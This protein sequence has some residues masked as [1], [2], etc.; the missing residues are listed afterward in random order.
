MFQDFFQLNPFVL[1]HSEA[2]GD[3]ILKVVGEFVEVGMDQGC[4][5]DLSIVL[6]RDVT[7]GHVVEEDTQGPHR[8]A[9]GV[10]SSVLYPLRRSVHVGT[11]KG[12]VDIVLENSSRPEIYQSNV[13]CFFIYDDV[14][15]FNVSVNDSTKVALDHCFYYLVENPL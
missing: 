14:L 7:A 13:F 1:P 8:E 10:V 9:V 2:A 12:G 3:Q 5:L 6:E 11:I 15:I 4:F